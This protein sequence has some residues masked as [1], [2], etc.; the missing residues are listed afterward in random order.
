MSLTNLIAFLT[1]VA[2]KIL[3]IVKLATVFKIISAYDAYERERT[4]NKYK[5]DVKKKQ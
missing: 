2:E 4:A 3:V 5:T 1:K